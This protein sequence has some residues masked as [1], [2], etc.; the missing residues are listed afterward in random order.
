R[1]F[2]GGRGEA[3]IERR[4]RGV[5]RGA[6]TGGQR[7]GAEK[8]GIEAVL[9]RRLNGRYQRIG[10]TLIPDASLAGFG[11]EGVEGG[12]DACRLLDRVARHQRV[13]AE[14]LACRRR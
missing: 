6:T 8:L 7:M 13:A 14:L 9:W 4:A 3:Q 12:G 10:A 5:I 2:E 11:I 1:V